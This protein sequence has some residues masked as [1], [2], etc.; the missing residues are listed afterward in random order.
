MGMPTGLEIINEDY[1]EY[2]GEYYPRKLYQYVKG[3][4]Q[5]ALLYGWENL[6]GS[7]LEGAARHKYGADY[8]RSRQNLISRLN[9]A[10]IPVYERRGPHN[11]RILVIGHPPADAQGEYVP[12]Q[13]V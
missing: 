8:K 4:Y 10:G 11:R 9:S 13:V 1:V 3:N 5:K 7:S 12:L 6:S 2:H